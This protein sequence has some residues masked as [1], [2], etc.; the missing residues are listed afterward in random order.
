MGRWNSTMLA[1]RHGWRTIEA[2]PPSPSLPANLTPSEEYLIKLLL[3]LSIII[4]TCTVIFK[5]SNRRQ[6]L[7]SFGVSLK[8]VAKAMREIERKGFHLAG[9][10]VPIIHH[11]LLQLDYSNRTCISICTSITF[12]GWCCDLARLYV[13][14]VQRN[15]PLRSIL[16]EKEKKQL[17]GGCYFSLGCT[18]SIAISPPS[19]AMASILFLVLGDL[20]AAIIGISFGG[21]TIS[22]KL[23]REGKKSLEGS[24]AMFCICFIVGNVIFA[25]VHLGEYPVFFGALAATIT[26]L[27][28]PFGI[29]DNLS[30]PVM[31]S[32]MM[33]Y[34][35]TRIHSC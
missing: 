23:G 18:L 2:L 35:F 28:E 17:T 1:L 21:E 24:L 4:L 14:V 32:L 29:N 34:A 3:T 26:E 33:Q 9:I 11:S 7:R 8:K 15:W 5:Q 13:P 6:L 10:L 27:Y 19:I 22:L 12:V 16:R 25:Q 31:S 20:S 30:I